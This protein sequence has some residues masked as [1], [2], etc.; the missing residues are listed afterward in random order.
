MPRDEWGGGRA[1]RYTVFHD[2]SK[3]HFGTASLR[4]DDTTSVTLETASQ[5]TTTTAVTLR[6]PRSS[7][8]TRSEPTLPSEDRDSGGS[9]PAARPDDYRNSQTSLPGTLE[10]VPTAESVPTLESV[11]TVEESVPTA[12]A[13]TKPREDAGAAGI[14]AL[15]LA[16]GS[17]VDQEPGSPETLA[18]AVP[19]GSEA[20]GNDPPVVPSLADTA[21]AED[22]GS[23]SNALASPLEEPVQPAVE[24]SEGTDGKAAGPSDQTAKPLDEASSPASTAA[25]P[26]DGVSKPLDEAQPSLDQ[27]ASHVVE[28][29]KSLDDTV[30]GSALVDAAGADAS[31]NSKGVAGAPESGPGVGTVVG[32]QRGDQPGDQDAIGAAPESVK[33]PSWLHPWEEETVSVRACTDT[34]PHSRNGVCEDGRHGRE[35]VCFL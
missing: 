32:D 11:P 5:Y 2:K 9:L 28:T 14:A 26:S 25:F 22:E 34:C 23:S 6:D 24:T 15:A 30:S 7:W 31:G 8:G 13:I 29:L 16:D 10:S 21:T 4:A 17:P 12:D 27:P 33:A 18:G 35:R 1:R 19:T 20:A 3:A